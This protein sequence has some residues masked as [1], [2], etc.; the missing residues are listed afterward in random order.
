MRQPLAGR[1]AVVEVEVALVTRR[2]VEVPAHPLPVGEQLLQRRVRDADHRDIARLEVG[3][4]AVETVRGRRAGGTP[5]L[6]SRAEHEVVDHQVR[7]PV[8]QLGQR[9]G[10]V[11]G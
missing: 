8:K 3:E 9:A 7:T 1:Y 2:P 10:P 11:L 5:G 4:Y 6:P